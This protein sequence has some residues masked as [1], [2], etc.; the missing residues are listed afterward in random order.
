VRNV[1]TVLVGKPQKKKEMERE[2]C[3]SVGQWYWSGCLRNKMRCEDTR[4]VVR[5]VTNSVLQSP[6]WESNSSSAG[7]ENSRFTVFTRAHVVHVL[8]QMNPVFL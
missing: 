4:A 2:I 5:K 3:V 1:F 6:H 8:S 7:Q